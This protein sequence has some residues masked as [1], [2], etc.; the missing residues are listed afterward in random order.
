MIEVITIILFYL[1]H[2]PS[3]KTL[4]EQKKFLKVY[5]IKTG[6]LL[7]RTLTH[8]CL[9]HDPENL[10]FKNQDI[11]NE[12]HQ[13]WQQNLDG[14]T[15]IHALMH[16]L[17]QDA[18]WFVRYYPH[19][20]P[21][22]RLFFVGRL[23]ERISKVSWEVFLLDC[24]YKTNHYWMLLCVNSGVTGLNTSFYIGFTFL[25][26]ETY[27]DY[28]WVLLSL[29]QFYNE[30]NIPDPIFVGIDCKKA[31][32]CTLQDVIPFTKYTVCLWHIDKNVFT[33]CKP[34]FDIEKSW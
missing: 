28:G 1:E 10:F 33:N 6:A 32:I 14:L 9:I 2:I 13:L 5:Y 23:S 15:P 29:Q 25:S 7:Q 20:G 16:T 21:I 11:Y 24:I 34:L 19:S 4:R 22:G 12:Q 8:I 18:Q 26:S 30:G 3:I 17:F 31:L 27:T